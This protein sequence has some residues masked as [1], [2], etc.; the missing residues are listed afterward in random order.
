L[1][2]FEARI[3]PVTMS[4]DEAS[5]QGVHAGDMLALPMVMLAGLTFVFGVVA[6]D[7]ALRPRSRT[8]WR[9]PVVPLPVVV[10]ATVPA[11][12]VVRFPAVIPT[13]WA[14]PV[15]VPIAAA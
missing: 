3:G 13:P 2:V 10:A 6:S 14:V 1:I 5:G 12:I 9:I 15:A 7:R 8:P 4:I 11:P